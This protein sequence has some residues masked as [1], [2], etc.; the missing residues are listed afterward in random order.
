MGRTEESEQRLTP[1]GTT[2][3][4]ILAAGAGTPQPRPAGDALILNLPVAP[5]R[6]L[7]AYTVTQVADSGATS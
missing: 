2:L 7:D 4:S 1:R 3:V 6:S 5:T